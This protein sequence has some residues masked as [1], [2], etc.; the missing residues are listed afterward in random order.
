MVDRIRLL[1]SSSASGK[2]V[3]TDVFWLHAMVRWGDMRL[4]GSE[5]CPERGED[6]TLFVLHSWQVA[7]GSDDLEVKYHRRRANN[8]TDQVWNVASVRV[9]NSLGSLEDECQGEQAEFIGRLGAI[10][11]YD[12]LGPL[13]AEPV[14]VEEEQPIS[15]E[16]LSGDV[17]P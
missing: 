3:N 7:A 2:R 9:L 14:F 15:T 6:L 1:E 12:A 13:L 8:D 10:L 11:L 4:V 17:S 16:P 5:R